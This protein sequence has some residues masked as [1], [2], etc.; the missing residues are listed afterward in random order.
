MTEQR[1]YR[2]LSSV[3][4]LPA[5]RALLSRRIEEEGWLD[6]PDTNY[7][8]GWG[9]GHDGRIRALELTASMLESGDALAVIACNRPV[10]WVRIEPV[11]EREFRLEPF[12]APPC[13]RPLYPVGPTALVLA[14][15]RVF[16]GTIY[17][18]EIEIIMPNHRVGKLLRA[19]G[20]REEGRR[21]SRRWAGKAVYDTL[22]FS[23]TK[24]MWK[25]ARK[26]WRVAGDGNS[27]KG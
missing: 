22:A 25:R 15:D 6:D 18:V 5:T 4:L 11:A 16:R 17:R 1:Q 23:M 8:M 20:F 26:R 3:E 9:K 21:F 10:G 27:E 13:Q 12:I 2:M 14:L 19:M 7:L 24:P